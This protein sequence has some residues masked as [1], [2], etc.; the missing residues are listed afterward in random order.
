MKRLAL[1]AVALLAMAFALAA[2]GPPPAIAADGPNL[3][4]NA[5]FEVG[6]GT[7]PADW[8]STFWGVDP[9][10][11]TPTF[12]YV[13]G[14]GH[15]GTRSV[16]VAVSGYAAPGDAKWRV[17][18]DSDHG[19]PV[20]VGQY[21]TFSDWYKSNVSTAVSVYYHLSTDP[22][23]EGHWAN[24]FTGI[25]KADEWT[26]YTTGFTM[27]AKATHAYFVHF[28]ARDGW[29]QTDDYSM[30]AGDPPKGF[31]HP[32]VSLTFDD[33]SHGIAER[34]LPELDARGLTSTQYIPTEH[35]RSGDP[36]MMT[37]AQIRTMALRHEVASHSETHPHLT[38]ITDD[39]QLADELA[40]PKSLLE[41]PG[42]LN[43]TGSVVSFAYPF[44]EYDSRVIAALKAAGY[45]SGR[46]VEP[47]YN[48]GVDFEPYDIR[49]QNM[50]D[51][52][53]VDEFKTWIEQAKTNNYWLS[54]VYHEVVP[55][56]APVCVNEEPDPCLGP[57]DTTVSKFKA[58]L[59][60]VEQAGLKRNVVTVRDALAVATNHYPTGTVTLSSGSPTT[61]ATLVATAQ[62]SDPDGDTLDPKYQWF[63]GGA[64]I[65][66]A[67]GRTLDLSQAGNGDRGDEIR[68]DVTVDDGREGVAT[69]TATAKV[70][71]APPTAGSV[72]FAPAA[73][74]TRGAL[75]ATPRAFADADGDPLAYTY[76][77]SRN[78]QVIAGRTAATLPRGVTATGDVIRVSVQAID[79][80]GARSAPVTATVT[81]RKD[82]FG[83]KIIIGSP[84]ARTYALGS[85]VT[86]RFSCVDSA[87]IAKRK[88]TLR[89]VGGKQ[90][91]VKYGAK[92]RL[93]RPGRYVL[94]VSA[95]DRLGN[96]TTKTVR[97]RVSAR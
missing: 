90:R 42:I 9:P 16:K 7:G 3:L 18:Q 71:N 74:T 81:V 29:L 5:S 50:L 22:A 33:G 64:A 41:G 11:W 43:A 20:N 23:N 10:A 12:T 28:I 89:R 55:D 66:G 60:Y 44:G 4:P 94:R 47:G 51:T 48:N 30:R 49:V 2:P 68:V 92:V 96:T 38:E 85:R 56:N 14:D 27:P 93:S 21:Y 78:G 82:R 77:W 34:A 97:F 79:G 36:Y 75:T 54:I 84:K 35:L 32:M 8:T 24:L 19:V 67:T 53:T 80:S 72:T 86:I 6:D 59:D 40:L 73:P 46:S 63:R 57:Y 15:T 45:T 69:E 26:Q 76:T 70:I 88:A 31:N 37:P 13:D 65:A 95:T 83:P 17:G 1:L 52:T 61:N 91:V 58:Q 25:P 62:F 87:G 39:Q